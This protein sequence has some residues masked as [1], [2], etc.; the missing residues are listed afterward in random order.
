MAEI[1]PGEVFDLI[2][3]LPIPILVQVIFLRFHSRLFMVTPINAAEKPFKE[4]TLECPQGLE[5]HL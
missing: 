5:I 3:V 1:L 2:F 4:E